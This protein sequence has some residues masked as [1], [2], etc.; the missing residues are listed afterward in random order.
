MVSS[1]L[2]IAT[3]KKM[4]VFFVLQTM[5]LHKPPPHK[6][7]EKRRSLDASL[8]Q[9]SFLWGM[10][11]DCL[12]MSSITLLRFCR[13]CRRIWDCLMNFLNKSRY[14]QTLSALPADRDL[15]NYLTLLEL[16]FLS[17]TNVVFVFGLFFLSSL[18]FE[19]R[20]SK[21]KLTVT[22]GIKVSSLGFNTCHC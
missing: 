8:S 9:W 11:I 10:V 14:D 15:G 5:L 20:T 1:I 18:N 13:I 4:K 6:I 19:F 12:S 21:L 16:P 2:S 3:S 7:K 17:K 22:L